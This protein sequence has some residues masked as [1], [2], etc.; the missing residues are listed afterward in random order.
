MAKLNDDEF[1]QE[2]QDWSNEYRRPNANIRYP[3]MDIEERLRVVEKRL[4][5]VAPSIESLSKYPALRE[6]YENYKII[7][8]LTLGNEK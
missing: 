4:L 1:C 6:A 2:T 5:I 7:E 8:R 3:V